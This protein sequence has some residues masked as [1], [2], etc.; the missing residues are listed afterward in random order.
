MLDRKHN[1]GEGKG[2]ARVRLTYSDDNSQIMTVTQPTASNL[3][4]PHLALMP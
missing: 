2:E 1:F 3:R 4:G